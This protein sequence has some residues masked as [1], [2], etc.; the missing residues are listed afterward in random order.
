[1]NGKGAVRIDAPPTR[2]AAPRR[3]IVAGLV[4]AMVAAG[5]VLAVVAARGPAPPTTVQERVRAVAAT[6]RC[7]ICA[8]LSVADSPSGLAAQ[9]RATIAQDLRSGL[10]PDQIRSRFVAA[11]GQWVLLSPSRHGLDL[12]AWIAPILL[13][14]AGLGLGAMTVRRWSSRRERAAAVSAPALGAVSPDALSTED[15]RLLER[16][17]RTVPEDDE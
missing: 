12:L 8:D 11:Y 7:P 15:R 2:A 13:L 9:M 3:W 17:L 10:T 6:L 5:V 1:M 14:A 16:A 4:V